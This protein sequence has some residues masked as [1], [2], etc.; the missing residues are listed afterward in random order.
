[1]STAPA[2]PTKPQPPTLHP[3][4]SS[5]RFFLTLTTLTALGAGGVPVMTGCRL[6]KVGANNGASS[7]PGGSTS[8]VSAS[9]APTDFQ[10]LDARIVGHRLSVRVSPLVRTSEEATALVLEFTRAADDAAMVDVQ[11]HWNSDSRMPVNPYMTDSVNSSVRLLDPDQGRVWITTLDSL[12]YL[13]LA[14]GESD[15][16]YIPFGPVDIDQVTAFIPQTG[17]VPL[18]VIDR[19]TAT[20]IGIDLAAMDKT[21]GK[22]S[23]DSGRSAPVRIESFTE[24]LDDST[25]T[26]T[27]DQNVTVTLSSDVTFDSDS[28]NLSDKADGQLQ[29][30]AGQ[31]AQHPDGGNL[32]IVGHTD[33]VA[34]D[35]HNQKLSEDR[36]AAVK[37]RLTELADLAKWQITTTGKGETEPAI[38]D[39]TD[40]ARAAN[41]RVAITITPTSG[42]TTQPGTPN[43]ATPSAPPTSDTGLPDA[44][45]PVG[46]GPD[47]VTVPGPDG[48]GQITITL[49]HVTRNGGLL[50]AQLTITTG[51]GGTDDATL[52][53]WLKDPAQAFASS[54][55]ENGGA[56]AGGIANGL[57]LLADGQRLYPTDYLPP[58]STWHHPLTEL[59][60]YKPLKE[61]ATTTICV[62][63]PDTAQ[64]TLTLDH[65]PT[66]N[67]NQYAYRLTNIPVITA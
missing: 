67:S 2:N 6:S 13:I 33:D 58:D 65:P 38:N 28:A 40:E 10:T 55:G 18:G 54:R 49:D 42:T 46:T 22:L 14:P 63:W 16:V 50:T 12:Q 39:T 47:G 51:P 31:L 48:K 17:F 60:T 57:T 30:V 11:Q 3:A 52:T 53:T 45:G 29:T 5:R 62:A 34:D 61:G 41:R 43:S 21:L 24:A 59:Y 27:T 36:A 15:T 1:M 23:T 4:R 66:K 44:Q 7:G 25:N 56:S 8:P 37:T 26:R 32:D 19:D 20:T 64:D 35:A 9:P